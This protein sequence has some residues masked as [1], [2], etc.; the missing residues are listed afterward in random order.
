MQTFVT[1]PDP[2]VIAKQLDWRRLNKQIT[3]C[4]QIIHSNLD[5][6]YGWSNHPAVKMW[7]GHEFALAVYTKYMIREWWSRGY[8]SHQ[9]SDIQIDWYLI[10]LPDTGWP[11]W[12]GDYEMIRTHQSNLL[13]KDPE[14]YKTL[15]PNV[16]NNLPYFWP[17]H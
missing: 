16:N 11:E 9:K 2:I 12:W 1:D 15:F 14:Y 4:L 17:V 5:A 3:E 6:H 10:N 13:R 7:N 8:N